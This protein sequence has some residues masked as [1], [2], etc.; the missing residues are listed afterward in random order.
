MREETTSGQTQ[1]KPQQNLKRSQ[2]TS[3]E[4]AQKKKASSSATSQQAD[5]SN[6]VVTLAKPSFSEKVRDMF[7]PGQ[8]KSKLILIAGV[9]LLAL[10]LVGGGVYYFTSDNYRTSL[11]TSR[12]F[13]PLTSPTVLPTQIQTPTPLP[14]ATADG[15]IIR[16][17]EMNFDSP[18]PS[19]LQSYCQGDRCGFVSSKE[20]C[21]LVD[22]VAVATGEGR[23]LEESQADGIGDCIWDESGSR[24]NRCKPRY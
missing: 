4:V 8:R 22:V 24:F 9:A 19:F 23:L 5:F 10:S 11:E 13:S 17:R 14:S 16:C 18:E 2:Q 21:E 7:K 15:G 1:T 12:T 3:G 20:E 6:A